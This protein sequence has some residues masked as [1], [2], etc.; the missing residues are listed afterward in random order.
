[1]HICTSF[2][3]IEALPLSVHCNKDGA[4]R[5]F[6]FPITVWHSHYNFT[7]MW[8][9]LLLTADLSTSYKWSDEKFI[10]DLW[11]RRLWPAILFN[12]MQV[13]DGLISY[14]YLRGLQSTVS[15]TQTSFLTCTLQWDVITVGSFDGQGN[16]NTAQYRRFSACRCGRIV[17]VTTY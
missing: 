4:L 7:F 8:W 2:Y 10:T 15:N 13:T 16:S 1:M 3:P 12:Y 11:L 17:S 14:P 5:H 9:R 6:K